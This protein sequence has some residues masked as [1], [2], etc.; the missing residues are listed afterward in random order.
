M[1]ELAA[2]KPKKT[3]RA[4]PKNLKHQGIEGVNA[5][6]ECQPFELSLANHFLGA[7][8]MVEPGGRVKGNPPQTST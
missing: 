6:V 1:S 2:Q 7:Q 3:I 5:A 8:M 4:H